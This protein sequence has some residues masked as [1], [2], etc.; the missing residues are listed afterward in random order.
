[1]P[2][3]GLSVREHARFAE[4]G[5]QAPGVSAWQSR[6]TEA[7]APGRLEASLRSEAGVNRSNANCERAGLQSVELGDASE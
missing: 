6:V 7:A 4:R 5:G 1:M 3:E 2:D